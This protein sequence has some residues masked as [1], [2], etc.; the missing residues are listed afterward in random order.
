MKRRREEEM[1]RRREEEVKRR[2]EVVARICK[3]PKITCTSRSEEDE[4]S[5]GPAFRSRKFLNL[6]AKEGGHYSTAGWCREAMPP[7]HRLGHDPAYACGVL[8]WVD[9]RKVVVLP[10]FWARLTPGRWW[11]LLLTELRLLQALVPLACFPACWMELSIS[12]ATEPSI[13]LQTC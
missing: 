2:R 11:F 5:G 13:G 9:S 10:G 4:R 1:K 12:R 8:G 7:P 6:F 3:Q